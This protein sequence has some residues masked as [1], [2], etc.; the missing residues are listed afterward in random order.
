MDKWLKVDTAVYTTRY[1]ED[2]MLVKHCSISLQMNATRYIWSKTLQCC[3][4]RRTPEIIFLCCSGIISILPVL[5]YL[6]LRYCGPIRE[7]PNILKRKQTLLNLFSNMKSSLHHQK[8]IQN[9][10]GSTKFCPN[11][12]TEVFLLTDDYNS[13][14]IEKRVYL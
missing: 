8:D 3:Q 12:Y 4:L 11:Q 2:I 7:L 13:T 9:R 6:V 10:H 14:R 5:Y 1:K